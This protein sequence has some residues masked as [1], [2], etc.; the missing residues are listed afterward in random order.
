M[1]A[2]SGD[3]FD[4]FA[5]APICDVPYLVARLV[6]IVG[7]P[8]PHYKFFFFLLLFPHDGAS[9]NMRVNTA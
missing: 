4:C 5:T 1:R 6:V 8:I 9:T 7:L 3:K 2:V